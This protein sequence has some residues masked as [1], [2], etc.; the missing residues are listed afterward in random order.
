[1]QVIKFIHVLEDQLSQYLFQAKTDSTRSKYKCV[2]VSRSKGLIYI[3][4]NMYQHFIYKQLCTEFIC[5]KLHYLL[6]K[7]LKLQCMLLVLRIIWLVLQIHAQLT[8]K[9]NTRK[10]SEKN[11]SYSKNGRAKYPQYK[12]K[13]KK[14]YIDVQ[15]I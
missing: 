8:S 12:A 2:I 5:Q 15:S 6:E 3:V 7:L 14:S 10:W 13:K 11:W 4:L 1:M 9:F